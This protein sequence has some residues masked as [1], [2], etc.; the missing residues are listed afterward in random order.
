MEMTTRERFIRTLTGQEKDRVPFMKI[1]GGTAA[2]LGTWT[3]ENPN[4]NSYIDELLR[5]EGPYRGWDIVP[6]NF[7]LSGVPNTTEVLSDDENRTIVRYGDGTIR[8]HLKSK[9]FNSHIL[10]YPV[11]NRNDWD[12]IKSLYM[13]PDD[14]TRYPIDWNRYA[15]MYS[16]RDYPLQLT[17]GGVFGFARNMMGDENLFYA[18]YDDPG[19]VRDILNTYLNMCLAI[20][21]RLCKDVQFDL[22]ECWEDMAYKQGSLVSPPMFNEFLAPVFRKI[23]E[24]ADAHNIPVLLVDS[25][26]YIDDLAVDMYNAGVNA[27]YPFEVQSSCDVIKVLDKLPR[28]G[29]IGCLNKEVMAYGK[30]AIDKELEKCFTFLKYGR[31]I[32]GPDHF[33]LSNVTFDNY[34]YFMNRLREIILSFKY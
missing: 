26:G 10:E 32:P 18:I 13:N 11:K 22:I 21:E 12:K 16:N 29:A 33:V 7:L 31:I 2:H 3:A 28:M 8:A 34:K 15:E 30:A 19:F 9:N 25:D 1:F 23:R 24:F 20:W 14:A 27:M 5:F 6:V 4:I 17:Y